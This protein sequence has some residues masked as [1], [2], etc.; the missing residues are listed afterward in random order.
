MESV[1]DLNKDGLRVH[2]LSL[3]KKY[4]WDNMLPT[5]RRKDF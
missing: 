5:H 4:Q 3:Y 2:L 1:T